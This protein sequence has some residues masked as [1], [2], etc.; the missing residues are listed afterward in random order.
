MSYLNEL[1][2]CICV[3]IFYVTMFVQFNE[4]LVTLTQLRTYAFN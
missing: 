4:I 3:I 1:E 2:I